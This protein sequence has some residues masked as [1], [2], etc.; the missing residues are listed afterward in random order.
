MSPR[1]LRLVGLLRVGLRIRGIGALWSGLGLIRVGH[2]LGIEHELIEQI[3]WEMLGNRFD[4]RP[5]HLGPEDRPQGRDQ[6]NT[7]Q[8]DANRT[9]AATPAFGPRLRLRR[10]ERLG[11]GGSRRSLRAA[12]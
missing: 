3:L 12:T 8:S 5:A 11:E 4:D 7:D 2:D 10:R 1:R 6:S 9:Q